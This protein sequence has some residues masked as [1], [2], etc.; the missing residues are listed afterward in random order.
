MFFFSFSRLHWPAHIGPHPQSEGR[1]DLII[2]H[3]GAD[4]RWANIP[5]GW[6]GNGL[7]GLGLAVCQETVSCCC[8]TL[9]TSSWPE[10]RNAENTLCFLRQMFYG[11]VLFCVCVCVWG[12]DLGRWN[13]FGEGVVA[14][15]RETNRVVKTIFRQMRKWRVGRQQADRRRN[16]IILCALPAT[17]AERKH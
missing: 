4:T 11:G 6:H 7:L 13:S 17:E 2:H 16:Q 8:H 3:L 5:Y 10:R 1:G 15:T 12:L 14:V 9:A